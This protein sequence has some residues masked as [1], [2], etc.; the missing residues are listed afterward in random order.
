[1]IRRK[2]R[3]RALFWNISD[4]EPNL[5]GFHRHDDSQRGQTT[6]VSNKLPDSAGIRP[7]QLADLHNFR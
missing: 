3:Y 4:L 5:A 6:L 7:S 2:L 1:M